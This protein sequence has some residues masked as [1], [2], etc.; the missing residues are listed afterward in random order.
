MEELYKKYSASELLSIFIHKWMAKGFIVWILSVWIF[1]QFKLTLLEFVL[2]LI[3]ILAY[4][5][6][7]IRAERRRYKRWLRTNG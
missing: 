4:T 5:T 2:T 7:M 1:T 3:P 6:W